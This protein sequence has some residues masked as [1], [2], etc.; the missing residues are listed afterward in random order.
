MPDI[1]PSASPMRFLKENENQWLDSEIGDY[2]FSSLL[3]H[4]ESPTKLNAANVNLV[5]GLPPEEVGSICVITT[6]QCLSM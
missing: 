2:S 6:L 4:L 1:T 5:E 3:G